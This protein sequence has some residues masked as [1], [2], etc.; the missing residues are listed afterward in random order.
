MPS[1]K[2]RICLIT[3]CNFVEYLPVLQDTVK[4]HLEQDKISLFAIGLPGCDIKILQALTRIVVNVDDYDLD[5]I[6]DFIETTCIKCF[7]N[8]RDF[9]IELPQNAHVIPYGEW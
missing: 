2:P 9:L 8:H 1:Y 6:F 7:H 4:G 3:D 5:G